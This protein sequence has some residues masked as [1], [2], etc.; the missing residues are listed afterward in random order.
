[1][2]DKVQQGLDLLYKHDEYLLTFNASERSITHRL[3]IYYQSVFKGFDVDC[4]FNINLGSPKR[5]SIRPEDFIK[6]MAV[7]LRKDEAV[8]ELSKAL[9]ANEDLSAKELHNVYDQL[10]DETRIF[11]DE[12]FDVVYFTL[13]L[14]NGSTELKTIYPDIIVHQRQTTN[15]HVVIECKKSINKDARS[16]IYDLIKLSVLTTDPDFN[17]EHGYFINIPV[18]NDFASKPSFQY[19]PDRMV[20]RIIKVDFKK[21]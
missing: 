1:M 5:M 20:N 7:L 16:R 18:Q 3:G 12:E 21:R 4:E 15:N 2:N 19:K 11:Y 10:T 13:T 6:R 8:G 17:Y 9:L 14:R